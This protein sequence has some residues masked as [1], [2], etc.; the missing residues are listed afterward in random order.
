VLKE[1]TALLPT[2]LG[3]VVSD[4]LVESFP[5]IMDP[6]FTAAMET[7]LD[8]IAEGQVGWRQVMHDFYGNFAQELGAARRGMRKMKSVPTNLK[9]PECGRGLVVRWGK[10]GEFMGCDAYPKCAFTSDFR[11]DA[12]GRLTLVQPADAAPA[13]QPDGA[14]PAIA[15]AA[16]GKAQPSGLICPKCQKELLVRWGRNGEFLGCSGYPKCRFT[17]NFRRDAQ[18]Q[19]TPL[20]QTAAGGGQPCPQEG[21]TGSLAQR[22]SRRGIFYGCDRYPKCTF[23]LN[24]APVERA[25]PQCGFTWLQQKGKKVL[26]PK[27]GC[28]YQEAPPQAETKASK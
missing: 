15:P 12:Q 27:P 17:Q 2:E 19:V 3:L 26:C 7:D 8:R 5:D 14:A 11:R 1:K 18:G 25:C 4:L 20:D 28:G 16:R 21:C 9:C 24:Q 23:T 6:K 10:N 22:R 13:V